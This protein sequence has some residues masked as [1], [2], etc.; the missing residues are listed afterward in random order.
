[1][2]ERTAAFNIHTA[3][4]DVIES[5]AEEKFGP[6]YGDPADRAQA[7]AAGM[8]NAHGEITMAGWAVSTMTS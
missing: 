3:H 2:A 8:V 5:N 4:Q 6:Q 7:M 1:M